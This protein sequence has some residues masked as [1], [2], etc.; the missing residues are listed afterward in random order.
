VKLGEKKYGRRVS[1]F[2]CSKL[3]EKQSDSEELGLVT[4]IHEFKGR[5][6]L[7]LK[8][9]PAVLE[10]LTESTTEKDKMK[11]IKRIIVLMLSLTILL[12]GMTSVMAA[13]E[14]DIIYAS[15]GAR[16]HLSSIVL[17]GVVRDGY[18]HTS[19]E[20][21]APLSTVYIDLFCVLRQ[22]NSSGNL[23]IVDTWTDS[24]TGY[25]LLNEHSYSLAIDGRKYELS[26]RVGIYDSNG[27]VGYDYET[28]SGIN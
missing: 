22:E 28:L 5:Q 13:T 9:E 23:V 24:A 14:E 16:M 17:S 26:V 25:E 18:V 20:V 8:Q 1:S 21:Y 3:K 6:E 11:K 27:F 19:C 4:Q 7:Y 15:N 10:K 2:N 12:M